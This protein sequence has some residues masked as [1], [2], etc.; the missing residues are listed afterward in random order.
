MA[1]KNQMV[2]QALVA[3]F[4]ITR[5]AGLLAQV[6]KAKEIVSNDRAV[7]AIV[8]HAVDNFFKNTPQAV[9]LSIGVVKAGKSYTYN[10]G[11]VEKGKKAPPT[12]NT[13]YPI[14]S[15]TK[16]FTGVLLAQAALEGRIKLDDNVGKY[17]DGDYPNLEFQSYPI[18]LFDLLDHRSGLPFFIPNRPETEPDFENNV[19]PWPTRIANIE[20]SY[21][22]LNFYDDLHKVKLDAVPGEKFRYSNAGA[23][24]TG[25]ILERLYGTSYEALLKKKI[26][27]PL[28]MR[29]TTISLSRVQEARAAKGYDEKGNLMPDNPNELQAAGAI[30]STV[31]DMLK[32]AKWN[33][34]E[35][36]EAVRL[37][38]K[39]V[40]TSGPYAAGLNWQEMNGDGGRVIWQEGNI[41]G[42]NAFCIVEP[43]LKI[44]LVIFANEEDPASAHGQSV[45]ANEILTHLDPKSV[46]LP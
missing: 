29:A 15:I 17:L 33:I 45:L 2:V 37:S 9:G 43:E 8:D 30:K 36:S 35:T 46:L 11:T 1:F 32:Y 42:F 23:M 4:F 34:E 27:S 22:R 12:A 20:K 21:T 38:H 6:P 44:G 24:L 19:V 7:T 40:L 31:N 14:A 3:M 41:V 26:F 16:T 18:R 5:P 13:L 28:N 39:P 25:Y 10:Y